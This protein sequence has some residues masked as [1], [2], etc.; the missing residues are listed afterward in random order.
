MKRKRRIQ[1]LFLLLFITTSIHSLNA[2]D[3]YLGLKTGVGSSFYKHDGSASDNLSTKIL[4]NVALTYN[5]R[6]PESIFGM[7]IETGFS[8]RG[9]H[10]N[11]ENLDYR[12]NFVDLPIMLDIY[13]TDFIRLNVGGEMDYLASAKNR[14]NDGTKEDITDN[15]DQRTSFAALAGINLSMTYFMDLGL[16]YSYPITSIS[17]QDPIL[18]IRNTKVHYLQAYM[19][20]KIAN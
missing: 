12:L 6:F 15:F 17:E 14:L 13:P 11:N 10:I 2:Q 3:F 5:Y 7:N 18:N 4:P 8:N 16:R 19:M 20:L 1:R 9:I